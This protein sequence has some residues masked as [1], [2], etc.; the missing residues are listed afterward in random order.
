MT[1]IGLGLRTFV[2]GSMIQA[3]QAKPMSAMPSSVFGPG[4]SQSSTLIAAGAEFGYLSADVADLPR[5]LGLLVG[6]PNGAL[7][8]VQAGAVAVPESDGVLVLPVD[9][10]AELAVVELP[11]RGEVGGQQ[12]GSDRMV[13]KHG[14]VTPVVRAPVGLRGL[15]VGVVVE[16]VLRVVLPLDRADAGAPQCIGDPVACSFSRGRIADVGCHRNRRVAGGADEV[17]RLTHV[18]DV[19]E[20]DPRSARPAAMA[21][22]M[23]WAAPVTS[24]TRPA[25]GSEVLFVGV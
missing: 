13:S 15:D 14:N 20:N 18:A 22:P 17:A 1:C 7:G 10:Q 2:A 16:Q 11:G 24:A 12:H 9:L 19:A 3:A 21:W 23:P 6:G 5:C 8:H 25:W 4:V